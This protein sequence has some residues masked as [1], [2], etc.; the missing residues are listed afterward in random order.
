MKIKSNKSDNVFLCHQ[1]RIAKQTL[2]MSDI[3]ANIMGG[4]TKS[5]AVKLLRDNGIKYT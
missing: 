2:K 5:K 1:I 3:G 4:M